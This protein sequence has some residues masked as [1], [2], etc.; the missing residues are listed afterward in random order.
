MRKKWFYAVAAGAFCAL[1]E[2]GIV[3]TAEPSISG[4]LLLQGILAWFSCGVLVV[5]AESGLPPILHS[6]FLTLLMN[7]AWFIAESIAKQ[8]P[9]HF[10]PLVAA[11]TVLGLCIGLLRKKG[12]QASS[13][14]QAA[15]S[16]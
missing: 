9:E 13:S 1:I 14:V 3:Y 12:I 15:H 7:S 6:V 11:S 2:A 4:W 10:L 8:K 16:R 5:L